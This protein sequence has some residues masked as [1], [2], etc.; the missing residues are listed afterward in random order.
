[1]KPSPDSLTP[2]ASSSSNTFPEM[3]YK[4]ISSS[5]IP[6]SA[7]VTSA[8]VE[9]VFNEDEVVNVY[10]NVAVSVSTVTSTN[11]FSTVTFEKP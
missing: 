3:L 4:I 6:K 8:I 9:L 11:V 7:P 10:V 5:L 2:L 1:M